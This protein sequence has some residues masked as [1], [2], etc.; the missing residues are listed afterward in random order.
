MMRLKWSENSSWFIILS[1]HFLDM[2]GFVCVREIVKI[3]PCSRT[4]HVEPVIC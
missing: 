4:V 3:V 1:S 2:H